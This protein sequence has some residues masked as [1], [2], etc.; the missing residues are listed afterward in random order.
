MGKLRDLIELVAAVIVW[1]LS[2]YDSYQRII[3]HMLC[4]TP[5]FPSSPA[6]EALSWTSKSGKPLDLVHEVAMQGMN[7][8]DSAIRS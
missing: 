8:D 3:S 6:M 5:A 1:L 4:P 2:W 7:D